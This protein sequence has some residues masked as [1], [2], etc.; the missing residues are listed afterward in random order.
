[1][2]HPPKLNPREADEITI[3]RSNKLSECFANYTKLSLY[4]IK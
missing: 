3:C 4:M 1:M 2:S